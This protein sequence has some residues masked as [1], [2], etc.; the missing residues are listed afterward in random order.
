MDIYYGLQKRHHHAADRE[1]ASRQTPERC[2]NTDTDRNAVSYSNL[3]AYSHANSNR[4]AEPDSYGHADS[5]PDTDSHSYA[6]TKSNGYPYACA[7]RHCFQWILVRDGEKSRDGDLSGLVSDCDRDTER[8]PY[9]QRLGEGQRIAGVAGLGQC[10]LDEA[11]RLGAD[12][13]HFD[14]DEIHHACV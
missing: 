3:N 7:R 14:L 10:E 12:Q 2:T 8:E 4:D 13:C 1:D 9:S 5:K 6:Y 11:S